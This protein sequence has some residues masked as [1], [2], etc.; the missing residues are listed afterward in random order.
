MP[1]TVAIRRELV[2]G[3]VPL[4]LHVARNLV[5]AGLPFVEPFNHK[6]EIYCLTSLYDG[7]VLPDKP[8]PGW[9]NPPWEAALEQIRGIF[10]RHEG[11]L[12][13]SAVEREGYEVFRP[14]L[15]AA[16]ERDVAGW[17]RIG[18]R[19]YGFFQGAVNSTWMPGRTL[20]GMHLGN[21]FAPASP[22]DDMPARAR[23]LLKLVNDLTRDRTDVLEIGTGSWLNSFPPFAGLF[24]PEWLA[25]ARP[26]PQLVLGLGWWG[27]FVDRRGGF[28][29]KNAEPLRRTGRFPYPV[30]NCTC[31]IEALRKHLKD[32]LGVE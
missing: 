30:L 29:R 11:D 14:H 25:G 17:P 6:V 12:D 8:P 4:C 26:F 15:E 13:S 5:R 1:I 27:Q 18:N 3:L 10:E 21:P 7:K 16:F 2:E 20:I 23:E 24:P 31:S 32:K 22:F 19:P 9:R 28:H